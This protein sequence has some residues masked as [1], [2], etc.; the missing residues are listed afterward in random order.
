MMT[1]Y[2]KKHSIWFKIIAIG[3]VCLFSV[4]N[5]SL[6]Q[7]TVPRHSSSTLATPSIFDDIVDTMRQR[8]DMARL[9]YAERIEQEIAFI[10]G[11]ALRDLKE[12]GDRTSRLDINTALDQQSR[13]GLDMRYRKLLE[14]TTNPEKLES[15][16]LVFCVRMTRPSERRRSFRIAFNGDSINDLRDRS[17][18]KLIPFS[19]ISELVEELKEAK[20]FGQIEREAK[21]RTKLSD[22]ES[23][24]CEKTRHAYDRDPRLY[25]ELRGEEYEEAILEILERF[26]ELT[27][28]TSSA[29]S[30]KGIKILDIG[31][32]LKG[33]K[34]YLKQ[35]D[36]SVTGI[37]F[38]E[39]T[40][41]FI[42]E[43]LESIQAGGEQVTALV[44][45]MR[46]LVF[47]DGT[48]DGV[49]CNSA[50]HHLPLVD[51]VQGADVAVSEAYRVL[52]PGGTYAVSVKAET[53]ERY[54]FIGIEVKEKGTEKTLGERFFQFY[55]EDSLRALLER[56]GF[57]IEG[58]VERWQ[59]D[60]GE[61]NIKAFAKKPEQP[62]AEASGVA[63][64]PD[65]FYAR[66]EGS[67][68]YDT[69]ANRV[70]A[71]LREMARSIPDSDPRREEKIRR[72][73][74]L[75]EEILQRKPVSRLYD[76]APDNDAWNTLLAQYEG[77][78]WFDMPFWLVDNYLHRKNL[79]A[80]MYFETYNPP[81]PY[82]EKKTAE[83][84]GPKGSIQRFMDAFTEWEGTE[85]Q[86]PDREILSHLLLKSLWGNKFD[87]ISNV[88][89]EKLHLSHDDSKA[90]V[91]YILA[92]KAQRLDVIAD[93]AGEEIMSDL[94]LIDYLLRKDLTD[95]VHLHLK[96][97]PHFVSDAMV[98]DVQD[99]AM[100]KDAQ[101]IIGTLR[102]LKGKEFKIARDFGNRLQSYIDEG[103][104]LLQE[105]PFWTSGRHFYDMPDDLKKDLAQSDLVVIKGDLQ[106]RK[107]LGDRKWPY[108][109]PLERTEI[110][111]FPAPFVLI[112]TIKMELV[113][114][115]S[116]KEAERYAA[117]DLAGKTNGSSGVIQACLSLK[118]HDLPKQ[119]RP[120]EI[121][122]TGEQNL[123]NA[124]SKP[125]SL[126]D[127]PVD[128]I[129]ELSLIP[130][131]DLEANMEEWAYRMAVHHNT[132]GLNIH[133][134]FKSDDISYK[135]RAKKALLDTIDDKMPMLTKANKDKIKARIT[136]IPRPDA[137]KIH[138]MKAED[139]RKMHT[140]PDD[141][142]PVAM[143]EGDTLEGTPLRD[144]DAASAIGLAQAACKK[145]Q[146]YDSRHPDG[147]PTLP[148]VIKN[149]LP[150]IQ[151]M[152]KRLLPDE[153]ITEKTVASMIHKNPIVR[154]N[155]AISL[156]LPPIVR[157]AINQLK[158]YHDRIQG[159]LR[160]A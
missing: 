91:D 156:A 52:K 142:L 85:A 136:D 112:R 32:D 132:Y 64:L 140:L 141:V 1:G 100:A 57:A 144:F 99:D 55:S 13:L 106:Y 119:I 14:V 81:D 149:I 17:K 155:L 15:G 18:T 151:K 43:Q 73:E 7:T 5:I 105:H 110:G 8:H 45:D 39:E 75:I 107:F 128:K 9:K 62:I 47:G 154:K 71:A 109:T 49:M 67:W 69:F 126:G 3:L 33:L 84:D 58:K 28:Q 92:N 153:I 80:I 23:R 137:L 121:S 125:E 147:E 123:L 98:K 53:D 26:M 6:A 44:N 34:W 97:R 88:D 116:Q 145:A 36:L 134:I 104:L 94:Y 83:L 51:S 25:A 21:V 138:I 61:W 22:R 12:P 152:Y 135:D 20:Q 40:I 139:L 157:L 38:S 103:K 148:G 96:D 159:L 120:E 111:E 143:S 31:T 146:M 86:L 79:E 63:Q 158:D 11:M 130:E 37:D 115:L 124:V 65:Y 122:I 60:R 46:R 108:D 129:I 150:G 127:H 68:A 160:A 101:G 93:N 29:A 30:D 70:P 54:G 24:A 50:L 35:A 118:S 74:S 77:L 42:K 117:L 82:E 56:H 113:A 2:G 19:P 72:I 10:I 133:Y 41:R 102:N 87:L 114:G 78:S 4:N 131:E 48:F 95:S 59:D 76:G 89:V 90:V 27:R 66:E 16:A